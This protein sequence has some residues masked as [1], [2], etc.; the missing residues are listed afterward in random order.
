MRNTYVSGEDRSEREND[1]RGRHRPRR[2]MRRSMVVAMI[3]VT[4]GRVMRVRRRQLRS[5]MTAMETFFTVE[6][7]VDESEHVGR[8]E[9][10]GEH[11]HPPQQL[12]AFNEGLE[13]DFVL[14][15]EAG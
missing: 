10:R 2:I 3:V 14:R 5:Y 6:R 12:M 11:S 8:R 7:Q 1:E 15:E 9:E 13:Q 4:V